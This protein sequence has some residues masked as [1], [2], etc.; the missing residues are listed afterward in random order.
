M[1]K[2]DDLTSDELKRLLS[3]DPTTGLF[4]WVLKR[5]GDAYELASRGEAGEFARPINA[6]SGLDVETKAKAS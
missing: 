5:S 6:K 1:P 2:R 3:Y 4:R